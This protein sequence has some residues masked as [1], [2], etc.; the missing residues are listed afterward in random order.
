MPVG[1]VVAVGFGVS[2]AAAVGLGAVVAVAPV[3]ALGVGAAVGDVVGVGAA[4]SVGAVVGLDVA[5]QVGE[6]C[7]VGTSVGVGSACVAVGAPEG[8]SVGS[9]ATTADELAVAAVFTS[10]FALPQADNTTISTTSI[11][12]RSL[13]ICSPYHWKETL[14]AV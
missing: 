5:V 7:A 9:E 8:V 6:A 4:V 13:F 11:A 2:V 1:D 14:L 10:G 3:V 12:H